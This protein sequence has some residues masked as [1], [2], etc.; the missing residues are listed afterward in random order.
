MLSVLAT[1]QRK[2]AVMEVKSYEGMKQMYAM[3][4]RGGME[5]AVVNTPGYEVY[6]RTSLEAIM[7]EHNFQR[8]GMVKDSDIKR[9]GEMAGVQYI[10]VPEAAVDGNDMYI[11]V[12]MLDVETGKFG[13]VHDVLCKSNSNDI[14]EACKKLG[15]ELF[16][17]TKSATTEQPKKTIA[18]KITAETLKNAV[19]S[20]SASKQVKFAK[21]NLQYQPS[22]GT[23]RFAEHQWDYIGNDNKNVSRKYSGWIDL[24]GWGTGDKP[25]KTS[26]KSG[27]YESFN[28]WG[29]NSIS[30]GGGKTWHTLS[31]YEWRYLLF[32]RIT[33]SG[34]RF[35]KAKVNGICGI[36]ILPDNWDKS[37]Y[38]LV[39]VNDEKSRFSNEISQSDWTSVFEACGAVF[40][41]VAGMR[42]ENK[43]NI[44]EK[45]GVVGYYWSSTFTQFFK[46][47]P[48][49]PHGMYFDSTN[50]SFCSDGGHFGYSVRLVYEMK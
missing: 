15:A 17:E 32:N 33:M 2:V 42:G 6:D 41:P 16:G 20:V 5:T 9:L 34:V 29:N 35:A 31:M 50:L 14:H 45:V 10:I 22:T 11:N 39:G 8:S 49:D 12:K 38:S 13:A 26:K 43:D 40:L 1:A 3:M 4:I 21:G 36:I 46:T 30:N 18:P 23:W 27:D 37:Y 44:P 24:F 19:F 28:E 47:I 48:G 25:T 7:E